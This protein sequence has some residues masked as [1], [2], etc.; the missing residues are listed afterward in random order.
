M[1]ETYD[2]SKVEQEEIKRNTE[3]IN[4]SNKLLENEKANAD[5]LQKANQLEQNRLAE[6]RRI[7]DQKTQERLNKESKKRREKQKAEKV[8]GKGNDI[9]TKTIG[10]I[11][12]SVKTVT[13]GIKGIKEQAT[14]LAEQ[15]QAKSELQEVYA[16]HD[17]L[18]SKLQM[19]D[20]LDKSISD[21]KDKK[22]LEKYN[23]S[24][25]N[26]ENSLKQ[27]FGSADRR[28]LKGRLQELSQAKERVENHYRSIAPQ[29]DLKTFEKSVQSK[30]QDKLAQDKA[31]SMD[32]G[33]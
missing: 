6:E 26:I 22:M 2:S 20:K 8:A 29:R 9:G 30:V 23:L 14:K 11:E 27:E 25:S 5:R 10:I 4:N 21:C 28:E 18:K 24:K 17:S 33:R 32:K 7:A 31:Q 13:G 19:L 1:K 3:K 16:K 15:K 12:D